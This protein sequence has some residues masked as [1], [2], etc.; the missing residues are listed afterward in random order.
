M[1]KVIFDK[2]SEMTD[3]Y[4]RKEEAIEYLINYSIASG[5]TI[6]NIKNDIV[7]K[8]E[9]LFEVDS[10]IREA[11]KLNGE[12][13][14]KDGTFTST[15]FSCGFIASSPY[16]WV[17]DNIEITKKYVKGTYIVKIK[18][19]GKLI[20]KIDYIKSFIYNDKLKELISQIS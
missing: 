9:T 19:N 6:N 11:M 5:E 10:I 2:V 18:K 17:K 7:F 4:T 13:I 3:F 14:P 20:A 8:N 15:L 1:E 12:N 16:L